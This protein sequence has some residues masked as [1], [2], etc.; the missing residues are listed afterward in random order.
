[1]VTPVDKGYLDS[2]HRV[3]SKDTAYYC[4]GNPLLDGRDVLPGYRSTYD[5]VLENKTLMIRQRLNLKDN[6]SI[7]PSSASLFNE[8]AFSG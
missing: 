7:L 6:V 4:F 1:M 3:A 8:L 2:Y 5:L